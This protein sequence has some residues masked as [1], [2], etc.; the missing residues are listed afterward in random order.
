VS[1]HSPYAQQAPPQ[2]GLFTQVAHDVLVLAAQTWPMAPAAPP[3]PVVPP[4]CPP[5]APP[6]P[7]LPPVAFAP[8]LPP[9]LAASLLLEVDPHPIPSR[10]RNAI[11]KRAS[12]FMST[13]LWGP[14]SSKATHDVPASGDCPA[15]SA[16]I[17]DIA[18]QT[19]AGR[20]PAARGRYVG[21][22][23]RRRRARR[24]LATRA[25]PTGGQRAQRMV[26]PPRRALAAVGERIAHQ[27]ASATARMDADLVVGTGGRSAERSVAS[28]PATC[29][30]ARS[31]RARGAATSRGAARTRGAAPSRGAA[32]TRG[33]ATSRGTA[34][35]RS[36]A[37]SAG[38]GATGTRAGGS[39]SPRATVVSA[40]ATD[41]RAAGSA[42]PAG[43]AGAAAAVRGA[44]AAQ[45]EEPT[46]ENRG[47]DPSHGCRSRQGTGHPPS[48]AVFHFVE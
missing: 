20:R 17:A 29:A 7:V 34:R 32:R 19:G 11:E 39:A 36:S 47:Q 13:I 15:L 43:S 16:A 28:R 5:T 18:W 45:G 24:R 23:R 40:S 44:G 14:G 26:G 46:D 10:S 38:A 37:M 4:P 12:G 9:V 41:T 6:V 21:A 22:K 30:C 35:T 25:R 27:G 42:R 3:L 2:Q 48:D 1:H 8:P 33:A 31:T